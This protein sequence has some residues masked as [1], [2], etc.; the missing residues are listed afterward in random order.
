MENT[1]PF[2]VVGIGAEER[3][4]NRDETQAIKNGPASLPDPNTGRVLLDSPF[5]LAQFS[6]ISTNICL[7]LNFLL[8]DPL[9]ITENPILQESCVGNTSGVGEI[10]LCHEV[11]ADI[12]STPLASVERRW[13]FD[14]NSNEFAQVNAFYHQKKLIN[15]YHQKLLTYFNLRRPTIY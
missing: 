2:E 1:N 7:N 14:A 9:V 3:D 10:T 11:K 8:S 13:G 5:G 15:N 12:N 4:G 6:Y